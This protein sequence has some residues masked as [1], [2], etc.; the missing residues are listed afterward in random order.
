MEAIL[1][2]CALVFFGGI[3]ILAYSLY[4]IYRKQYTVICRESGARFTGNRPAVLNWVDD[5]IA[6]QPTELMV[7]LLTDT[8][9]IVNYILIES[10]R[11][12]KPN[13]IPWKASSKNLA[14]VSD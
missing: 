1:I 12:G 10:T 13:I 5:F 3:P 11:K 6:S 9:E 8:E 14:N 7:N 4:A 2:L